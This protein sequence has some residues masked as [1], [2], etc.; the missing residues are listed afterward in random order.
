MLEDISFRKNESTMSRYMD[1]GI[2]DQLLEDELVSYV[3][4]DTTATLLFSDL[5]F[6]QILLKHLGRKARVAFK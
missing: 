5:K 4:L 2:A 1:P 3:D 6:T